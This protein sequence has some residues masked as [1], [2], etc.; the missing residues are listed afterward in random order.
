[1][2]EYVRVQTAILLRRLAFQVSRP[3]KSSDPESIHDLRVAIRRFSGC[4]QLFSQFYPGNSA[5]KARHRLEGMMKAAGAVRDLDIA[6]ELAAEAG[7]AK[8]AALVQR[9]VEERR[10]T[11]R[12]LLSEVREWKAQGYSRKWRS[13]LS[14][15]V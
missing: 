7:L 3:A 12:Q 6:L 8:R 2:H 15:H 11:R 9:L 14:L 4:L 13:S 1:M 10:N 5:K